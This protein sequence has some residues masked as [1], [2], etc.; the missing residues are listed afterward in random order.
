[1]KFTFVILY[2]NINRM[3]II[4]DLFLLVLP[5]LSGTEADTTRR[6]DIFGSNIIPPKPPKSFLELVWEALQDVTLIIL[7]IAAIIS[8]AL[9]F[10]PV[11]ETEGEEGGAYSLYQSVIAHWRVGG[12]GA[13]AGYQSVMYISVESC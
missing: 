13:S 4:Y 7:I 12:E 9:S 10:Y 8:L 2:C 1:M 11:G 3:H 6:V 5:G